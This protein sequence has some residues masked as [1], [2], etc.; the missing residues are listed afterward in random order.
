MAAASLSD[1]ELAAP[2]DDMA[3][4]DEAE[5]IISWSAARAP[6]HADM[7]A[8]ELTTR[9]LSEASVSNGLRASRELDSESNLQLNSTTTNI[10]QLSEMNS[11][12]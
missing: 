6:A 9:R 10:N 7:G 2:V 12:E 11:D 5:L 3:S 1:K 4:E 8:W